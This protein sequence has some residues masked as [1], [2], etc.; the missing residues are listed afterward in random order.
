MKQKIVR[1]VLLVLP[2][3]LVLF[4]I[5]LLLVMAGSQ[6]TPAQLPRQNEIHQVEVY[7]LQPQKMRIDVVATG[8]VCSRQKAIITA[9]VPGQVIY[10]APAFEVGRFI[11]GPKKGKTALLVR[12]DPEPFQNELN[13]AV[14]E[15]ES[16]QA[17]LDE[18]NKNESYLKYQFE[19]L[20]R[21]L[22]LAE[23]KYQRQ[24]RLGASNVSAMQALETAEAEL[25]AQ[26][27]ILLEVQQQ[28]RTL[29]I[30]VA[31][32]RAS[33]KKTQAELAIAEKRLRQTEITAPFASQVVSR[34]VE[35]G[36]YVAVGTEL[37]RLAS[38]SSYEVIV[39]I[40][41][42]QLVK[43]PAIPA[44]ALPEFA[45][46]PEYIGS[47]AA[48]VRWLA[49][50]GQYTWEGVVTR[51]EPMDTKTRT[52][53]VAVEV[54]NPW[55]PLAEKKGMPLMIGAFCRVRI[56]GEEIRWMQI[57]ETA[58]HA[59]DS[60]YLLEEGR[61]QIVNVNVVQRENGKVIITA[62]SSAPAISVIFQADKE[63]TPQQVSEAAAGIK[64][65]LAAFKEVTAVKYS[66]LVRTL[67]F[68]LDLAASAA[69]EKDIEAQIAKKV[70]AITLPKTI[71]IAATKARG[72][73]PRF[74]FGAKVVVSPL[75][76]P[77]SGMPL[78]ERQ[79]DS[80][81]AKT[82]AVKEQRP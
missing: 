70:Q 66:G 22:A 8:T 35:I 65:Q 45:R 63:T 27:K 16:T 44:S 42:E 56:K 19:L 46:V 37:G 17:A 29:P 25:L 78:Q 59:G 48:T 23:R 82:S 80:T 9:G 2:L 51:L 32:A 13:R 81:T 71:Q 55:K 43:L 67:C 60:I 53:P 20:R 76:Y 33:V 4:G 3:V 62:K 50:Q 30:R 73:F 7:Q 39:N 31:Q 41:A 69:A 47:P 11:P 34:S 75:R 12:L 49:Y 10:L 26:K 40:D 21:Q 74:G 52:F 5:G 28:L 24:K 57:P 6:Q 15:L 72:Y 14:A 54:K 68:A 64:R 58:L 36:Q 79:P 38:V 61:L 18:L 77:V 1:A